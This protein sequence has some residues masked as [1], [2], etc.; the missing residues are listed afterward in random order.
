MSTRRLFFFL[1]LI[2]LYALT[3]R[4]TT[5]PDMWWHLRTGE[6]IAAGGIPRQDI[7]SFT[8]VHHPWVT[9]EWLAQ[10]GLWR[11]FQVGGLPALMLAFAAVTTATFGLIYAVTPGRPYLAGFVTLLAAVAS[12]PLWGVRP[13]MLT[14]LFMALFIFIIEGVKEG[15]FR[16]RTFWLLPLLTII[17]VNLHSG[18]LLGVVLAAVY[19]GGEG[20]QRW[21]AATEETLSW[22]AVRHLALATVASFLVAV[23]NPNGAELWI[24]PFQTLGSAAMQAYIVEW[25]SPNF[26]QYHFWPFLWLIALGVL[27]WRLSPR[28]ATVS[29]LLL[30]G[31]TA[32]AGL[33][34]TRHIPLF[35]VAATPIVARH[36]FYASTAY[37]RL[38]AVLTGTATPPATRGQKAFNSL[39]LLGAFLAL[40]L[41]VADKAATNEAGIA[42]TYPVAAVDF[43]YD[44]DLAQGRLFN[45]YGWGGYLI[46]RELPVFIDGRA[47]VYGDDFIF[48]YTRTYYGHE[49]W[50]E[51]LDDFAVEYILIGRRGVLVTLLLDAPEWELLYEDELARIFHRR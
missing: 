37:P 17:W 4:H 51:A 22:T 29:E 10:L 41:W 12:A 11:L 45:S 49:R 50:R 23:F 43:L 30:F 14:L 2:A 3:I 38:H 35:A 5:D 19:A 18:Y 27:S 47:D 8:A 46:W 34:S 7:F 36:L 21:W 33:I 48:Y 26:H 6:A 31:G 13:Q 40:W 20:A 15:R 42:A 25:H 9:H 1:F 16:P 32:V 44:N 24:Y 28:P 39:L